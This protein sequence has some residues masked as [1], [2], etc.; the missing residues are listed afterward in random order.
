MEIRLKYLGS[1]QRYHLFMYLIENKLLKHTIWII[2]KYIRFVSSDTYDVK[3][4]YE[5][6]HH[7][8]G[9]ESG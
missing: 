4:I 5:Q 9:Y 1:C 2:E 8:C 7:G 6:E 3:L